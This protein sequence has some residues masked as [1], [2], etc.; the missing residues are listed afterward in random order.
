M[1]MIC[2]SSLDFQ[3]PISIHINEDELE[4]VVDAIANKEREGV[5]KRS[6]SASNSHVITPLTKNPRKLLKDLRKDEKEFWADGL[7]IFPKPSWFFQP[8]MPLLIHLG[9]LRTFIVNGII[10]YTTHTAPIKTMAGAM[11]IVG[12]QT[13][14][15]LSSFGLVIFCI[16]P[17]PFNPPPL[18]RFSYRYNPAAPN[19]PKVIGN[20]YVDTT[21]RI[22]PSEFVDDN[23]V[24]FVL[25]MLGKMV[26]AEEKRYRR[27]SGLRIFVRMDVSVYRH[28]G[29]GEYQYFVNEPT[30]VNDTHFF[31]GCDCDFGTSDHIMEYL[32]KV[33]HY[34]ALKRFDHSAPPN[35]P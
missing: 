7:G 30:R 27:F 15:P 5:L 6:Q 21:D 28:T 11:E 24:E 14:R 8:Y 31:H 2:A 23:Y 33:L 16:Q 25:K 19:D 13:M 9:E 17:A 4:E 20:L 1:L 34:H 22:D 12:V 35:P 18:P 26:L 32:A 3:H 10:F 29:S